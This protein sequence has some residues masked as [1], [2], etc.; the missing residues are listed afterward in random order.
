M[1]SNCDDNGIGWESAELTRVPSSLMGSVGGL[2]EGTVVNQVK[3]DS[4]LLW[5]HRAWAQI[6]SSVV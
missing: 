4:S 6:P 2:V 1:V 5:K 3:I